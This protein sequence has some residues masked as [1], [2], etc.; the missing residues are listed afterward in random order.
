[1]ARFQLTRRSVLRGAGGVTLALPALEIMSQGRRA[2]AAA[3]DNKYYA[4][5]YGGI[6]VGGYQKPW[7]LVTP[8]K[9]GAAYEITRGLEPIANLQVKDEVGLVSGLKVPWVGARGSTSLP[10]AGRTVEFHFN[11]LVQQSAGRV[12]H[13]SDRG[14]TSDQMV[15]DAIGGATPHRSLA[16]RV[17]PSTYESSGSPGAEGNLSWG[18]DGKGLAPI[19]SPRLCYQS[20][21]GEAISDTASSS[22]F[23]AA[24]ARRKSIMDLVKGSTDR[25]LA[26][27]GQDD[28]RRMQL[29]FDEISSLERR[30]NLLGTEGGGACMTPPAPPADAPIG[31]L[32]QIVAGMAVFN[33]TGGWS[34]ESLRAELLVDYLAF[35][36]ACHLTRVATMQFTIDQSGVNLIPI[37]GIKANMHGAGHYAEGIPSVG[38]GPVVMADCMTWHVQYFC[39]LVAKLR[40]RRE[41]DGS[42]LLDHTA[43]VMFF[44]GGRGFDPESDADGKSYNAGVHSPHSTENMIVFMAGRAGGLKCGQHIRLN[45]DRHPA[46]VVLTAMEA[47]GAKGPLGAISKTVPEMLTLK[48]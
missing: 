12:W 25:L 48:S 16:F 10:P 35:A 14:P 28:R 23:Q 3:T 11:S 30:I 9:T 32:N 33:P 4:V 26:R 44:E 13:E 24:L 39:R 7:D 21:F 34:N 5:C 20:L 1:M 22:E 17:Q 37:N 2:A 29:H 38:A 6:S 36:F 43:M 8:T 45:N 31:G 41:V 19:V 40:E 15:A 47:V 42:S 46:E 18:R 27:L